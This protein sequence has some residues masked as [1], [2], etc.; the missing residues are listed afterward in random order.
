MLHQLRSYAQT[1]DYE[2][3]QVK[4]WEHRRALQQNPDKAFGAGA[5]LY[6]NTRDGVAPGQEIDM[7]DDEPVIMGE[8]SVDSSSDSG[9]ESEETPE[10]E[11]NY[12]A[13]LKRAE[14]RVQ[15]IKPKRSNLVYREEYADPFKIARERDERNDRIM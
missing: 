1:G 11:K 12:E 8:A 10:D 14:S 5:D 6:S 9:S 7:H 13:G 3:K 4:I 15:K 2:D